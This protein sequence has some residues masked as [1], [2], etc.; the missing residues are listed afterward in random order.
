V[1]GWL[2]PVAIGLATALVTGMLPAPRERG[3]DHEAA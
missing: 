3:D 1:S 2:V